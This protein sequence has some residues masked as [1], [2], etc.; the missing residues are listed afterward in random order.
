MKRSFYRIL[1]SAALL[2]AAAAAVVL[3]FPVS[4]E[5]PGAVRPAAVQQRKQRPLVRRGSG[6][7]SKDDLA[8]ASSE[9]QY[10]KSGS[11]LD[12]YEIRYVESTNGGG[13]YLCYKPSAEK[14]STLEDGTEVTVLA[15]QEKNSLV[16]TE[17]G[18]IGWCLTS[19]LRSDWSPSVYEYLHGDAPSKDDLAGCSSKLRQPKSDEW[20]DE[21]DIRYVESTG[22]D[23]IYLCYKPGESSYSTLEDGTQVAVLARHGKNSL[24]VTEYGEIGWCLSNKLVSDDPSDRGFAPGN[25]PSKADLADASSKLQYPKSGSW[26][27][28]YETRYVESTNGGGIYLCYKPGADYFATLEDGTEVTVLARQGRNSLVIDE[29]GEIG[30]CLSGCLVE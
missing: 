18:E 20:L 24:V 9:L 17:Y 6:R 28:D 4:H 19:M 26:L 15:R 23:G 21:Y 25:A 2:L 30:W 29:Y 12:Y 27:D 13:I 8:G 1:Q 7:P 5:A 22:G 3:L 10:P 11:W 14:F 16:I